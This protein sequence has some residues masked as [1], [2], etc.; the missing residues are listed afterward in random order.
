MAR[1]P[2]EITT[3]KSGVMIIEIDDNYTSNF[4]VDINGVD[5]TVVVP[6]GTTFEKGE[7]IEVVPVQRKT[8]DG[9]YLV[10]KMKKSS[11][12]VTIKEIVETERMTNLIDLSI[13]GIKN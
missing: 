10:K 8:G 5:I 1:K 7:V 9:F 11:A 3:T 4:S 12:K 13:F 2:Q 6:S